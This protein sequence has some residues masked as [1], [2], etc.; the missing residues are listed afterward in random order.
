MTY[1]VVSEWFSKFNLINVDNKEVLILLKR[2]SWNSKILEKTKH[3]IYL[4]KLF[5]RM[6][7]TWSCL[8]CIHVWKSILL[9]TSC[10]VSVHFRILSGELIRELFCLEKLLL[11]PI[12]K[13][14]ISDGPK[15]CC[16]K[17][18]AAKQK[19][20]PEVSCPVNQSGSALICFQIMLH[21]FKKFVC[22]YALCGTSK[23]SL[24][25]SNLSS[26]N[27]TQKLPNVIVS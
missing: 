19:I 26:I 16:L 11:V 4:E 20:G 25:L 10:L 1:L 24:S 17:L 7:A 27:C 5:M 22:I 14:I 12:C 15:T 13:C 9:S 18:E 8:T 3:H 6:I 2:I 21:T 23:C